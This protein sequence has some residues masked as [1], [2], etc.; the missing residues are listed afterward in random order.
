MKKKILAVVLAAATAFSMFG[1]SLSASAAFAYTK[2]D[3][4]ELV[5]SKVDTE[6]YSYDEKEGDKDVVYADYAAFIEDMEDVEALIVDDETAAVKSNKLYAYDYTTKSWNAFVDALDTAKEAEESD[7]KYFAEVYA[8][9]ANTVVSTA[10]ALVA[11][12]GNAYTVSDLRIELIEAYDE[13][14][15]V[16]KGLKASDYDLTAAEAEK[17]A[18]LQANFAAQAGKALYNSELVYALANYEAVVE[19]LDLADVGDLFDNLAASIAKAE[20][21]IEYRDEYKTTTAANKKFA[22][23]EKAL[24]AAIDILDDYS[25]TNS[26]IMATQAK[27]DDAIKAVEPYALAASAGSKAALAAAMNKAEAC[28]ADPGYKTSKDKNFNKAYA[29]AAEFC[30]YNTSKGVWSCTSGTEHQVL[31]AADDLNAAIDALDVTPAAGSVALKAEEDLDKI[32]A[33]DLVETDYTAKSWAAFKAA[34]DKYDT[35]VTKMEYNTAVT[36]VTKAV[37]GL[38]KVSTRAAKAEF[39]A[40]L[41]AAEKLLADKDEKAGKSVAAYNAYEAAVK[42]AKKVELTAPLSV[43]EGATADLE[44]AMEAYKNNKVVEAFDGWNFVKGEGW[45][46]YK[47]GE[48]VTGWYYDEVEYN[49]WFYFDANGKMKTGWLWDANYQSW[50]YLKSNGFM[51]KNEWVKDGNAWYYLTASGAMAKNTTINGYKVDASG[52]WVA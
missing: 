32:G 42:A 14:A 50:Y 7:A 30:V 18:A 25:V 27:L 51:A 26:K 31:D 23:L 9:L 12:T 4:G 45:Y 1:A 44:K 38:V 28:I 20:K 39:T 15:V 22:A 33:F 13:A 35:A 3:A 47:D 48:K 49:S 34:M 5:A 21:I 40:T 37:N 43:L 46:F 29:A 16:V 8:A 36:A 52:K 6:D 10:K 41:K 11:E 19:D 24:D 17:L 2:A